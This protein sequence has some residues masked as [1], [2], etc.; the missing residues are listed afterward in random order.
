MRYART[1]EEDDKDTRKKAAEISGIQSDQAKKSYGRGGKHAAKLTTSAW[2]LLE[3]FADE[4]GQ[5]IEVLDELGACTRQMFVETA[6][7]CGRFNQPGV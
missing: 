7:G 1:M 5:G 2:S 6:R 4:F 3:V